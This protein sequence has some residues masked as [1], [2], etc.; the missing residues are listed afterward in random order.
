M[1]SLCVAHGAL[2][3]GLIDAWKVSSQGEQSSREVLADR[4]GGLGLVLDDDSGAIREARADVVVAKR[5]RHYQTHY[6]TPSGH[7]LPLFTRMRARC[8]VTAASQNCRI[9]DLLFI[10]VD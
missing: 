9:G 3:C 6:Q 1:L 5:A 8:P 4:G 10:R 2:L 7:G